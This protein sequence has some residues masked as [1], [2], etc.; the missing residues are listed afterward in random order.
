MVALTDVVKMVHLPTDVA[1]TPLKPPQGMVWYGENAASEAFAEWAKDAVIRLLPKDAKAAL[2]AF[3]R[4]DGPPTIVLRGLGVVNPGEAA[5]EGT[6]AARKSGFRKA[7]QRSEAWIL[8]IT[9]F[10]GDS[11]VGPKHPDRIDPV[12][13]IGNLVASK[14]RARVSNKTT[15]RMIDLQLHRDGMADE[16]GT[17]NYVDDNGEELFSACIQMHILPQLQ[18]S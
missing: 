15:G 4:G 16:F 11:I 12:V 6:N 1:A 5:L 10:F 9:R 2:L 17:Y 18:A 7:S 8:G 3:A 14:K 13:G